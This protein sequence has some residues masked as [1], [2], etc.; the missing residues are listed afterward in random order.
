MPTFTDMMAEARH[1]LNE[2]KD[3]IAGDID[4]TAAAIA[5]GR[6]KMSR[7]IAMAAFWMTKQHGSFSD[8]CQGI[9]R[10]AERVRDYADARFRILTL[11]VAE[12]HGTEWVNPTK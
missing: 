11:P 10:E 1:Q 8:R 2:A 4:S 5:E 9:A 7:D 3:I 6:A 12:Y